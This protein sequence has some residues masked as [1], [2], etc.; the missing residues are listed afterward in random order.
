VKPERLLLCYV[1][2]DLVQ[3]R[4]QRWVWSNFGGTIKRGRLR[5]LVEISATLT[6][7]TDRPRS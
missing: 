4:V 5:N 7:I 2:R 6:L 1:I 3:F